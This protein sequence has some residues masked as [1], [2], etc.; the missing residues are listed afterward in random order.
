VSYYLAPS[1]V[2]DWTALTLSNGWTQKAGTAPVGYRVIGVQIQLRG[3]VVPPGVLAGNTTILTLPIAL[4]PPY[5]YSFMCSGLAAGNA[6]LGCIIT[7]GTD[8]AVVLNGIT[9]LLSTE[10]NDVDWTSLP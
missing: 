9:A 1:N 6:A 8:G 3:G 7:V 5:A 4:W 10:L 2:G